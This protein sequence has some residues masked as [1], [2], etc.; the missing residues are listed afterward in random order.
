MP[1][2]YR[3]ALVLAF[4][5]GVAPLARAGELKLTLNNGR[6]TLIAQ[7]VTVRQILA[8][9]ARLGQTTIVNG[10]K[11][12]GPPVTFQLVDR[13]EREVL[14]LVLRSA[15]GYIAAQREVGIPN[16]SVFDRVM[17][18]PTSRGPV[19]VASAAPAPFRQP[20]M[21]QM[22]VP[23]DDDEPLDPN[24]P[25]GPNGPIG[26]N[27]AMPLGPNGQIPPNGPY[28][29]NGPFGPNGMNP[30]TFQNI[31]AQSAPGT[32]PVLTA[33]RPGQLPA[34]PPGQPNPYGPTPVPNKAT[35]PGLGP[36]GNQ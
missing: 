27:G 19:G 9:W 2:I 8:E 4:L 5:A 25:N 23:L 3:C 15:G 34:P 14:E 30:T 24:G 6:A 36:G 21:A 29:V 33:P 13:P 22:P 16:A 10:D 17:I 35:V 31:P 32:A 11:L 1:K 20:N 7:D 26:P 28:G 12:T 18:L